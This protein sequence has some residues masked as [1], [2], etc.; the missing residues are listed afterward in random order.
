MKSQSFPHAVIASTLMLGAAVLIAFTGE[1]PPPSPLQQFVLPDNFGNYQGDEVL[2]CQNDQCLRSFIVRDLANTK[3]CP[4][5]GGKLD[6]ISPAER[7]GLPPD[8]LVFHRVYQDRIGQTFHVTVVVS[9]TEQKSIHR[10]QQCLPAQGYVI[11]GS[12]RLTIVADPFPPLRV[13]ILDVRRVLR[14]L[15]GREKSEVAS[16]AYWFTDGL[17]ETSSY[18]DCLLRMS[19]A[20]LWK[21][22]VDRWIYVG[23]ATSRTHEA[24]EHLGGLKDFIT[25]LRPYFFRPTA[26]AEIG[27]SRA[28]H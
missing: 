7:Q 22:T 2:F 9:G 16:Y 8:T 24:E 27:T 20:R 19:L 25:T 18:L 28:S 15:D 5:C 13:S 17:H 10:P 21:R 1:P 12:R 26:A 3:S 4:Y 6:K 11:E 14:S 23:V